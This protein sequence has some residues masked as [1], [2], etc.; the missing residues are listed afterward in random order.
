MSD[1]IVIH[2]GLIEETLPK[3][4]KSNPELAFS[5]VYCDTDL[6]QSTLLILKELHPR[7]SKGG[8]FVLDEWNS[9]NFPGEGV[10]VNDFLQKY[11]DYYA[12]EHIPNTRQPTLLLRKIKVGE[13]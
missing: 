8:V 11:G 2:K 7:L 13:Q 10:A 3:L 9:E 6:Y 1:E 4:I 12:Q 5:L